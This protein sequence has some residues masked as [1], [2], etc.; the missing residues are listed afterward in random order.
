MSRRK[1]APARRV[2]RRSEPMLTLRQIEVLRAVLVTGT[3]GGAARLLNVSSPGISR[4]MKHTEQFLGIKLFGRKG[5]R[6]TPTREANEIFT[7][8]NDVH[9]KVEDLH[10]II[11]R[12]KRGGDSELRIGSVPSLSMVMVPR[13]IADVR[14]IYPQ[15]RVDFDVL[16]IEEAVDYLLLGKGEA[17][18]M[19]YRMSHPLLAFEPLGKGRLKCIVWRGHPLAARSAV[20]TAELVTHPLIGIDP[21]DPYGRVMASIFAAQR[22]TYEVSIKARFG[23]TVCALVSNGLGVAVIDE[24]TLAGGNWPDLVAL[25]IIEPTEFDTFIATRIDAG[26]SS[27]CERFIQSLRSHLS[28]LAAL[29][30]EAEAGQGVAARLPVGSMR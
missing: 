11:E 20:S 28:R 21:N 2:V 22:L 29:G 26:L 17:V 8:I 4:V 19:S 3:I 12:L 14:R 16:K 13:A 25:D 7:Q 24:F 10:F 18:A 23:S 5:G 15:L 6:Y 1:P 9:D 27:Y 30:G